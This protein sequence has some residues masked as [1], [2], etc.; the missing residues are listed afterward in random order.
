MAYNTIQFWETVL[1]I[2]GLLMCVMTMAYIVRIRLASRQAKI[3]ADSVDFKKEMR[4][5]SVN[6]C[7]DNA[8]ETIADAL[9]RERKKLQVYLGTGLRPVCPDGGPDTGRS[10]EL[11][12]RKDPVYRVSGNL[13]R[14]SVVYSEAVELAACGMPAGQIADKV[15]LPRGEVE[16]S[17]KLRNRR[18]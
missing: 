10:F 18:K 17:I 4:S 9:D 6:P 7:V 15:Q 3:K 12:G 13:Q 5:L 1:D 2:T 11:P 16:L 8:F 14:K